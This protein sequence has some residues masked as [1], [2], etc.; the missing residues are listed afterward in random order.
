MVSLPDDVL[1]R[2]DAE[3]RRRSTSRSALTRPRSASP[4]PSLRH[5]AT[6]S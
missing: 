2:V 6:R 4:E 1:E 3:A 5:T